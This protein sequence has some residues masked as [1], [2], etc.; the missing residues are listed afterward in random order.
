MLSKL[1]VCTQVRGVGARRMAPSFNVN[2]SISIF[3]LRR[4]A[5]AHISIMLG[6]LQAVSAL[7][8]SSLLYQINANPLPDVNKPQ[9]QYAPG[10]TGAVATE[11][12]I[13][14]HIGTDLLQR[15]G[16][17]ADAVRSNAIKTMNLTDLT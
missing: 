16:N 3:I 7:S 4:R 6:L 14:S 11:S 13:C 5:L 17:A 12:D 1:D 15:G 9:E 10:H 8:F 2:G